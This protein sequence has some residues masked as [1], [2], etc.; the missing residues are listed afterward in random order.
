MYSAVRYAR[1]LPQSPNLRLFQNPVH[2]SGHRFAPM[3][4]SQLLSLSLQGA[5]RP[6][7][8]RSRLPYSSRRLTTLRMVAASKEDAESNARLLQALLDEGGE[9]GCLVDKVWSSICEEENAMVKNPEIAS[10]LQLDLD[11]D[12]KPQQLRF[13]YVDEVS[14][15]AYH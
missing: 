1:Y 9:D 2:R 8:R 11:D 14:L 15:A 7:A 12:G 3:L 6:P 10:H 5:V 13:L 4:V